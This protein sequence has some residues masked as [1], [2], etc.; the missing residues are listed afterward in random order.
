[1]HADGSSAAVGGVGPAVYPREAPVVL[2][3]EEGEHG[4][5]C[6]DDAGQQQ[7]ALSGAQDARPHPEE[8][9]DLHLQHRAARHEYSNPQPG[10]A[11]AAARMGRLTASLAP[12][13]VLLHHRHV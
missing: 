12:Q 6:G 1:M 8:R 3:R 4:R 7:E 10:H 5:A 2:L 11:W 13:H 9:P